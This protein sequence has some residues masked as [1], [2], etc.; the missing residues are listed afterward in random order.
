MVL[1][2]LFK[3]LESSVQEGAEIDKVIVSLFN[4][5]LFFLA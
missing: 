3:T 5:V 4:R 1:F 2:R